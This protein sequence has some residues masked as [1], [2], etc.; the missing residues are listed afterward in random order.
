MKVKI[1]GL[2]YLHVCTILSSKCSLL[3]SFILHYDKDNKMCCVYHLLIIVG[4]PN[5]KKMHIF[6]FVGIFEYIC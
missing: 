2:V 5:L 4:N 1:N 3:W 6:G